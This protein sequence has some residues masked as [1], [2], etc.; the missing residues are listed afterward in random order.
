VVSALGSFAAAAAVDGGD[1]FRRGRDFHA[2]SRRVE[3]G[4]CK[5]GATG[6]A[7]EDDVGRGWIG[8]CD[9]NEV[10]HDSTGRKVQYLGTL[11]A[12]LGLA[13][14]VSS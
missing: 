1:T 14:A 12:G 3:G 8:G 9:R 5:R 10:G 7:C 11:D 6:V 13:R 2:I 4:W